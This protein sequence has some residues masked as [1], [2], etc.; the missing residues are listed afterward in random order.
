[1]ST[2]TPGSKPAESEP[3]GS[4]SPGGQNPGPQASPAPASEATSG[5][6]SIGSS[7]AKHHDDLIADLRREVSDLKDKYLRA[8]ADMDNLRKRTE[9]EKDDAAKYANTR[10]ARD[11]LT[12]GDTFQRALASVPA[13]AADIDPALKSLVDGVQM[14]EREF[15]SVLDKH[16]VK[17][18]EAQGQPFNPHL[19]Q[20][21]M[22]QP[23]ADVPDGTVITVFQPGYTIEDRTLRPAMV[24]VSTGG[25]KATKPASEPAAASPQQATE[26]P[27]RDP[28]AG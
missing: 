22:Q 23:N 20:A 1:M 11:L 17:R 6:A 19:H 21:V 16:G 26:P 14:T 12:I 27:E 2:D 3:H 18:I 15:L 10:F 8:H 4:Q 9:R 13:G 28:K 5:P 7:G 25:P 24:I